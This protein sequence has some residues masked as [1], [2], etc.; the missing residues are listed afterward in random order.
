VSHGLRTPLAAIIGSA[1][2]LAET[3]LIKSEA[4]LASLTSNIVVEAE[5]L[6]SDIQKLLDAAVVSGAAVT[7]HF[8]WSEPADIVNAALDR[9]RHNMESHRLCL[10]YADDLPLVQVDPVLIV[11]ALAL[12]IDNAGRYSTPSSPIEIA[13]SAAEGEVAISVL[14]KGIGLAVS[15]RALV[16]Q[17]F[18][19]GQ[20]VRDTT[21]GSGLGLWIANAFVAA[22][23][24]RVSLEPRPCS[25]G[26]KVTM[27]LPA[28]SASE[29][30]EIGGRSEQ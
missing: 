29:M 3:P 4:R 13:V 7:P 2:I 14:D 23:R 26:T 22:C 8:A 11:Q 5:R 6:N 28:A 21:R 1:S 16:F 17:K 15:E 24:G 12:I 10:K 18:Y 30:R 27:Y 19:R 20:Q 25:V 9:E